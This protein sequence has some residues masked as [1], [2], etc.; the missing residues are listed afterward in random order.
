MC[1]SSRQTWRIA[2]GGQRGLPG[3]SDRSSRAT[4]SADPAELLQPRRRR[5]GRREEPPLVRR[6]TLMSHGIVRPPRP[7]GSVLARLR[8][9]IARVPR[10][11][12]ITYGEVAEAGGAPGG[13]RITVWALRSGKA[14]PW[15]RVVAAGGRIALPGEEGEEQRLRLRL[16]GVSFRGRRVR[17]D[18]HEWTPTGRSRP[19]RG[20][21]SSAGS[22][23]PV[24][25]ESRGSHA[26]T[27]QDSRQE[28]RLRA[29]R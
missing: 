26:P 1:V 8:R 14:L 17:M 29:S 24:R 13:A 18:L 9:V 4:S 6:E 25:T 5:R 21:Y 16:E 19:G 27:S 23:N 3:G 20:S 2:A 22:T 28:P 10:G 11:K 7:T 12:V 15:H